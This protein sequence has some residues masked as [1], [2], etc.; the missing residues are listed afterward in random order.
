[1]NTK[2]KFTKYLATTL[3]V[4][5]IV[6]IIG[7]IV[8]GVLFLTGVLPSGN[9]NSHRNSNVVLEDRDDDEDDEDEEDNDSFLG[10][11]VDGIVKSA[12]KGVMTAP[13]GK[14]GRRNLTAD[15]FS[16]R[17]FSFQNVENIEID[18]SIY[19][20][21]FSKGPVSDVQVELTNVYNGYTVE[22]EGNTLKLEEPDNL[23]NFNLGSL[24]DLLDGVGIPR[25][26]SITITVPEDFAAQEIELDGGIG[27]ITLKD[28][29]A[30]I[31]NIDAGVGDIKGS[32]ISVDNLDIDGGT[33]NIKLTD[34]SLGN[35]EIDAGVGNI[36]IYGSLHGHATIDCGVG[37]ISLSLNDSR[38]KYSLILDK[39]LGSMKLDGS[40]VKFD[41]TYS[42]NPGAPY[43]LDISGGVGNITIDF[44]G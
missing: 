18:S 26:A 32:R 41:D 21:S 7:G 12:S 9:H 15:D 14:G 35:T 38:D 20:I 23:R 17:N 16:S 36:T 25:A 30:N 19:T 33:G 44:A 22:Q 2:Q 5:L 27:D 4:L 42:E 28:I 43:S 8:S 29:A 31:L 3:A 1:M 6:A 40:K 11:L 10:G 24:F 13:D 39:G 34:T 37:N